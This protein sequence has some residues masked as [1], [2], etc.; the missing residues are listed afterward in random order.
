MSE[1]IVQDAIKQISDARNAWIGAYIV[2][3]LE[4]TGCTIEDVMLV[5]EHKDHVWTWRI[6]RKRKKGY[7]ETLSKQTFHPDQQ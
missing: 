4:K 7:F 2:T 6:T 5:E 3:F 1:G